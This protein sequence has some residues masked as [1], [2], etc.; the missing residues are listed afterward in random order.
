MQIV[1]GD[2][3]RTHEHRRRTV[4]FPIEDEIFDLD[5]EDY[6]VENPMDIFNIISVGVLEKGMAAW[7]A[8]YSP[9]QRAEL[10]AFIRTLEGTD[11]PN[12]K[13]PEGDLVETGS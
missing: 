1:T 11:P 13:A 7:E 3:V 9:E 5:Y 10:V 12:A 2:P 4:C 8:V 6:Y